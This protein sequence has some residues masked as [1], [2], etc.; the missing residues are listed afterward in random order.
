MHKENRSESVSGRLV[1]MCLRAVCHSNLMKKNGS[2]IQLSVKMAEANRFKAPKGYTYEYFDVDGV[3]VEKLTKQGSERSHKV[4]LQLHGGG[5]IAPM[6]DMYRKSAVKFSK[7]T[8]G[9]TVFNVDYRVAPEHVYPAALVDAEKVYDY[10]LA[11]GYEPENIIVT[12]DSAG[13]NLTMALVG[14]LVDDGKPVPSG[15]VAMS[16]WADLA[17]KGESYAETSTRIHDDA[18]FGKKKKCTYDDHKKYLIETVCSPYAGDTP[19]DDPGLS[20]VYRSYEGYPPML[21]IVGGAE[22][23]F[24]DSDTIVKKAKAAG[25]DATLSPYKGVFH[26]F[27]IFGFTKEAKLA[28]REIA[29]WL[30]PRF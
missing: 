8:D 14:K 17:A 7:L 28:W 15:I 2:V 26:V 16:P 4:V 27:P 13:G 18:M 9:A 30:A 29:E 1:T 24:S 10:L 23:L 19:L 22:L 20:P 21:V 25:V 3:P 12:G 6:A 5:Y 11:E